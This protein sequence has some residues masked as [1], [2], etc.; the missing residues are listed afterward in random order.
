MLVNDDAKVD[1]D[2]S[3]AGSVRSRHPCRPQRRGV[4]IPHEVWS[5]VMEEGHFLTVSFSRHKHT[6]CGRTKPLASSV[7][8]G[9]GSAVLGTHSFLLS[10]LVFFSDSCTL[11]CFCL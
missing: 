1:A 7:P 9:L 11:W 5:F 6:F 4:D 10:F 3:T 8:T 2:G